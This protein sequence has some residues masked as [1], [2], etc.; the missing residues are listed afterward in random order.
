MAGFLAPIATDDPLFGVRRLLAAAVHA[1]SRRRCRPA[2]GR[3]FGPRGGNDLSA[4]GVAGAACWA[5]LIPDLLHVWRGHVGRRYGVSDADVFAVECGFDG[6][7]RGE[8]CPPR[9]LPAAWHLAYE[10][11]V[12]CRDKYGEGSR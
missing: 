1:Y 9:H 4:R 6:G 8:A 11:G 3:N 10:F 7:F 12:E 5:D 2:A